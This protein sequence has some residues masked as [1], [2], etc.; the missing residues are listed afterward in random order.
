[1]LLLSAQ[2]I[3]T[4]WTLVSLLALVFGLSAA[5]L[6]GR[7]AL[8][9]DGLAWLGRRTLP[10]YVIHMPLLA[11]LHTGACRCWARPRW[12]WRALPGPGDGVLVAA[13]LLI[14]RVLPPWLTD[15]PGGGFEA[16]SRSP[17]RS[18][19]YRV[20]KRE[21]LVLGLGQGQPLIDVALALV[22]GRPAA[23][24]SPSSR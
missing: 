4:V 24:C 15:L 10:I 11:L 3:P 7:L 18:T 19:R 5:P 21:R 20:A 13:C 1:M 12:S 16:R 14:D 6:L 2:R 9:G 22:E 17:W 8:I 23:R